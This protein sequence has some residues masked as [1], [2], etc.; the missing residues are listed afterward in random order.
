MGLRKKRSKW[1]IL[2]IARN[3]KGKENIFPDQIVRE[4]TSPDL[5]VLRGAGRAARLQGVQLPVSRA[6]CCQYLYNYNT[7][8][9]SLWHSD[10]SEPIADVIIQICYTWTIGIAY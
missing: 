1:M 7:G 8:M 6:K 9:A 5:L 4:A 2:L 3:W 10:W